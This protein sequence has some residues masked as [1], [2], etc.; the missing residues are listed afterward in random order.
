MRSL[1]TYHPGL[2]TDLYH[3]DAA[4]VAWRTGHRGLATFDLYSRRAPFGGAYMLTA[5]LEPALEFLQAFRYAADDLAY[6]EQ[7]RDYDPAFLS[8]LANLR[9][10]GEVLAMREGTVAFPNEPILRVTAPY[11]EA[12]LMESG[13]LQAVNGGTVVAT[14]AA[15]IVYAAR[16]KRVAEFALRRALEPFTV[17]RSSFI[18]GCTSTSF[19]AGAFRFRLPATGS[20]PHALVQLFDTEEE[21]FRAVAETF[22]RYTLL[23]DTYDPRRA[24]HTAVQVAHWAQE[25]LGHSLAAVRIDAGD[26]LALSQEVRRVLDAGGLMETR[27]LVSGDMDEYKIAELLE[28]G[29]PIDAFGVGT[30]LGAASGSLEHGVEGGALG[31][32]YKLVWYEENG[33]GR[34]AVKIAGDKSTWPGKKRVY[35]A[36]A[37][38]RDIITLENE[39]A[40]AGAHRLLIPVVRGGQVL[41]GSLPPIGEVWEHARESLADLPEIFQQLSGAPAYPVEMSHALQE[42]RRQAIDG[43]QAGNGAHPPAAPAEQDIAIQAREATRSL[44]T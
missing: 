5:G 23:L 14:K 20:I 43:E 4:Y 12:L 22:S 41:P 27:I 28:Q 37:Y 6:L 35:R 11:V 34:P 31:G 38:E 17:A 30:A 39:P 16:G 42:L 2:S 29:A 15:R 3:P 18:G 8:Y 26:F 25:T 7:I 10:S 21:A 13:L 33:E 24:V 32:I 40:P 19:L 36:G 1:L 9:F 44:E